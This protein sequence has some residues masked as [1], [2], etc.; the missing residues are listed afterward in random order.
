MEDFMKRRSV[1][2]ALSILLAIP[3]LGFGVPGPAPVTLSSAVTTLTLVSG[4][5]AGGFGTADPIV[6]YAIVGGSSGQA[7][8]TLAYPAWST[9]IPGTRWVNTTGLLTP[10]QASFKTTNYTV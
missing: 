4:G 9:P 1:L 6:Q 8:I 10:D 7:R 3:L 5:G 2:V